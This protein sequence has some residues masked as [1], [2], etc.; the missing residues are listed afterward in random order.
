[1]GDTMN[2]TNCRSE[3]NMGSKF[4]NQCGQP[5]SS[6]AKVSEGFGAF[7]CPKC[8]SVYSKNQW[9]KELPSNCRKC[10][11][12]F[13]SH[14]RELFLKLKNGTQIEQSAYHMASDINRLVNWF[15]KL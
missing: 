13:T 10:S 2:C 4:C 15:K 12:Y 11:Y 3:I 14:D 6:V 5:T 9:V 8:E 1:M 7:H